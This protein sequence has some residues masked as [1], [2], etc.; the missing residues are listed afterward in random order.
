M[1]LSINLNKISLLR[2]SRGGDYPSVSEF[3]EL[4]L[5]LGVDGITLHPRPDLRH[6]TPSDCILIRNICHKRGKE[7]NMEGNPY[8]YENKVYPG[9]IKLVDSVKPTQTTL[10]PDDEYQI[11][12]DHG[13]SVDQLTSSL[14]EIIHRLKLSTKRISLFIDAGFEEF[15]LIKHKSVDCVE[16]YTGPFAN[17]VISKNDLSIENELFKIKKTY[18]AAKLYDL[19]VHIGHDL[20]LDNLKIVKQVGDFDEASIGHAFV[21][22]CIRYGIEGATEKY[23]KEIK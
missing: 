3:A 11:T 18:L 23:L 2:N 16:I 20:N 4:L 13:Y 17:A 14:E 5:D 15:E 8:C 1:N 6:A 22:D 12:S 7:F 9:F 10:V 21:V 19:R